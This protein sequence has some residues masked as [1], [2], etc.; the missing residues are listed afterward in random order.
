M[1]ERRENSVLFSLRELRKIE[2]NRV[3]QER[4]DAEAKAAA[5]ERA[6]QEAIRRKQEE[7]DRRR[8][9]EE[10]KVRAAEDARQRQ[11]RDEQLRLQDSEN[12]AR[13]DAQ[14]KLEQERLRLDAEH[15]AAELAHRKQRL[16]PVIGIVATLV[17][18]FG[19]LVAYLIHKHNTDLAAQKAAAAEQ[20]AEQ[21]HQL[22]LLH[23]QIASINTDITQTTAAIDGLQ[24]Q[25][26]Q[27]TTDAQRKAIQDQIDQ[28]RAHIQQQ[29]AHIQNIQQSG[30][31]QCPAGMC[32]FNCSLPANDPNCGL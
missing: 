28:Q 12:R 9:E 13:I 21:Q 25:L 8:Q 24:N 18:V 10:D 11:A 32:P 7:E 22:D 3:T 27:A 30:P 17:L 31:P 6:R 1:A 26:Q 20:Q 16:G 5:E 29:Q 14:M 2:D 19:G 23:Q 15:R 4:S